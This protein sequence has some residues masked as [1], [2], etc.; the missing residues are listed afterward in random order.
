VPLEAASNLA[1][2]SGKRKAVGGL[3]ASEKVGGNKVKE[4]GDAAWNETC[5]DAG[6]C[7]TQGSMAD[8]QPARPDELEAASKAVEDIGTSAAAFETQM[9]N[10]R[11]LLAPHYTVMHLLDTKTA[12]VDKHLASDGKTYRTDVRWAAAW[13]EAMSALDK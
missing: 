3:P 8:H 2:H 11:A 6:P 12:A 10:L 9:D 1:G 5:R 13:H 7:V 4:G